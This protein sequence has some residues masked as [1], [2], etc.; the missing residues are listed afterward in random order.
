MVQYQLVA[1]NRGWYFPRIAGWSYL[2]TP[3]VFA[4]MFISFREIFD[5]ANGG[6]LVKSVIDWAGWSVGF[7]LTVAAVDYLSPTFVLQSLIINGNDPEDVANIVF[8]Q[9]E[10]TDG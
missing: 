6:L 1:A 3:A 4:F 10:D 9:E 2:A 8:A 5:V 7:G